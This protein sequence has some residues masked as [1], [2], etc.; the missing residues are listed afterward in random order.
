MDK[1]TLSFTKAEADMLMN[2]SIFREKFMDKVFRPSKKKPFSFDDLARPI[3]Q[4]H[5][6]NKIAAIKELREASQA[7]P[8]YLNE[9]NSNFF[10]GKYSSLGLKEA[11]DLIEKYL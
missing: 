10:N 6:G 1:I 5:K 3:A 8:Q 9:S 2:N 7:Y 11:K 4:K